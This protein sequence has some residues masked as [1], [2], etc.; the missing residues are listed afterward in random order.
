MVWLYAG[1]IFFLLSLLH[2]ED[3]LPSFLFEEARDKV[4]HAVEYGIL[5]LFLDGGEEGLA[6]LRRMLYRR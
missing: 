5:S 4:L 1:I 3:A 6:K 2:P